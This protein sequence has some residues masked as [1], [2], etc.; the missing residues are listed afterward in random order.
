MID[1]RSERTTTIQIHSHYSWHWMICSP[2]FNMT[3]PVPPWGCCLSATSESGS[4]WEPFLC[5]NLDIAGVQAVASLRAK[6]KYVGEVWMMDEEPYGTIWKPYQTIWW[7]HMK[8]CW[9]IWITGFCRDWATMVS[10]LH[11]DVAAFRAAFGLGSQDPALPLPRREGDAQLL[12]TK[13]WIQWIQWNLTCLN[14]TY[15]EHIQEHDN[16]TW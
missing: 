6:R 16:T 14:Q 5:S 12:E 11:Q 2:R 13:G 8:P 15:L 4:R 10:V 7:N 1:D 3:W 9:T